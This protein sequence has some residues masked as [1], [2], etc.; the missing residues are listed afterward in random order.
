MA[1][2]VPNNPAPR[3]LA[4]GLGRPLTGTSANRHGLPDPYTVAEVR[5]QLGAA[6]DM[7]LDG[8][9][10]AQALPSTIVEVSQEGWVV[11]RTGAVPEEAL[12]AVAS[13]QAHGRGG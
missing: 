1:L 10:L 9:E 5:Q 11:L 12:R 6:I 13:G 8:G 7:T 2:R 3:A 4:A